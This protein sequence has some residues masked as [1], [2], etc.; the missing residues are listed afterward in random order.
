MYKLA[1]LFSRK[2]KEK[3]PEPLIIPND[4]E[5]VASLLTEPGLMNHIGIRMALSSRTAHRSTRNPVIILFGI[6]GAGKSMTINKL[7]GADICPTGNLKSETKEVIEYCVEIPS[8]RSG[9]KNLKLSVIDTPGYGDTDG[10]VEDAQHA[11]CLQHF[12]DVRY[13][14][15]IISHQVFTEH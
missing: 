2:S 10:S 9:I 7:F 3:L 13:H 8:K 5:A 4:S 14:W 1:S 15:F 12:F 11:V 6:T